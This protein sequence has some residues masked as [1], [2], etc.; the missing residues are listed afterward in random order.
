MRGSRCKFCKKPHGITACYIPKCKS[1]YHLPC[2]ILNGSVQVKEK[3][4]S[5]CSRHSHKSFRGKV[6]FNKITEPSQKIEHKPLWTPSDP[7]IEQPIV[8]P[9]KPLGRPRIN[10][11]NQRK[12]RK[13][14]HPTSS[15]QSQ[16]Q[17]QGV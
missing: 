14:T 6:G 16:S 17:A 8:P 15:S 10:G 11:Y 4:I 13:K 9:S 3:F 7:Q 12:A 5:Y 1:F 2:G